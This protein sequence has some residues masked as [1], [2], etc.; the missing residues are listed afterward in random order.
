MLATKCDKVDRT[1]VGGSESRD[2]TRRYIS[3]SLVDFRLTIPPTKNRAL[4]STGRTLHL[5]FIVHFSAVL[6]QQYC[7]GVFFL[8][9]S[10]RR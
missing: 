1:Y 8:Y 7:V 10:L 6:K 3:E 4:H 5:P 9:F 2:Q